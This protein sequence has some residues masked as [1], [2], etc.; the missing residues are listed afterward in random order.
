MLRSEETTVKLMAHGRPAVSM[1]TL[2]C[3]AAGW[4]IEIGVTQHRSWWR[5]R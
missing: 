2:A 1:N 3:R 5:S 4:A